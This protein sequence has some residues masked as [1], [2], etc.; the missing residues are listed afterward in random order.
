MAGGRGTAEPK[1][2]RT[3]V[4]AARAAASGG[5]VTSPPNITAPSPISCWATV[6]ALCVATMLPR[7]WMSSA[8]VCD[9]CS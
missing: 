1:P 2:R 9:A 5:F 4:Q 6:R 3:Q 8:H 7:A